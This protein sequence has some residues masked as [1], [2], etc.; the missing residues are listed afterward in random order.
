MLATVTTRAGAARLGETLLN[1]VR[2]SARLAPRL[3][4]VSGAKR[5]MADICVS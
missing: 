2:P 1:C 4:A 5:A 3:D